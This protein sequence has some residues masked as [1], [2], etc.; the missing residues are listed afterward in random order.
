MTV[1]NGEFTRTQSFGQVADTCRPIFYEEAVQSGE[2]EGRKTY[3][4]EERVKIIMPG[5]GLAIPVLKVTDEHRERWPREYEAFKQGLEPD[6]NGTP[7][8]EWAI[9]NKAQVLELKAMNIRTIED[10]AGLPDT[11]IQRIGRGGYALRERAQAYVDDAKEGELLTKA[12]ARADLLEE[13]VAVLSR[14]VEEMGEMLD[15]QHK[16]LVAHGDAQNPIATAV[17]ASLDAAES[18]KPIYAPQDNSSS[19]DNLAP[20]R[21][22]GRPRKSAA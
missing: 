2:M 6:L 9:L 15:R 22:R 4:M 20:K 7:L 5:N 10:V 8:E 13:K 21:S 18:A 19:F 16:V 11:A 17:P 14:Q 1:K 3:R 12:N